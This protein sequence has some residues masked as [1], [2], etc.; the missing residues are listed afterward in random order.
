MTRLALFDLDNTLID[1]DAAFRSWAE[2]FVDGHGMGAEE[3][4]RLVALDEHGYLPRE[5]LLAQVKEDYGLDGRVEDLWAAY[6]RRIPDFVH[7]PPE[8]R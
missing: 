8:V 3:V 4:E 2:E 7:C 1:R 5:T 6:R